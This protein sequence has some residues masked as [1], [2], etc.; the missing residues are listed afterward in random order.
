MFNV[1]AKY[2]IYE[3]WEIKWLLKPNISSQSF[4]MFPLWGLLLC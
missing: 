2:S 4:N 1:I 3:N